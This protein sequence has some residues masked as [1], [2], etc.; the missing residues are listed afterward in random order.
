MPGTGS[1]SCRSMRS[2]LHYSQRHPSS[3]RPFG[4]PVEYPVAGAIH[5]GVGILL[6]IGWM[7][8]VPAARADVVLQTPHVRIVHAPSLKYKAG[9]MAAMTP[10]LIRD[11]ERDLGLPFDLKPT[12]LPAPNRSA[13]RRLGGAGVV[14]RLCR[15][16]KKPGR[17]RPLPFGKAP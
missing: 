14:Y 6:L 4:F 11:L 2:A 7:A 10:A 13:F 15:T 1:G 17:D 5:L 16:P 8:F 12:V 3:K 9:R